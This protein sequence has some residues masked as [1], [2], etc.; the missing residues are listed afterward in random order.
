VELIAVL[1]T[2]GVL[3]LISLVLILVVVLLGVGMGLGGAKIIEG[4]VEGLARS[5]AQRE[6]EMRAL[7]LSPAGGSAYAGEIDGMAVQYRLRRI[8]S[9]KRRVTL[10]GWWVAVPTGALFLRPEVLIELGSDQRVGEATFDRQFVVRG[11]PAELA[12]L[13][14][15][16]RQALLAERGVK[17]EAGELGH[18]QSHFDPQAL[19]RLLP[20]ARTLHELPAEPSAR[21]RLATDDPA[22]A[23]RL[24]S[25]GALAELDPAQ[26]VER[27][28]SLQ[29][30]QDSSVRA[31]AELIL[32]EDQREPTATSSEAPLELRL[33]AGRALIRTGT[34]SQR[35]RVARSLLC[36][37]LVSLQGLGLE[38]AR[39]AGPEGEPALIEGV[40]VVDGERLG[41]L[42]LVLR[43]VGSV[44]AVPALRARQEQLSVLQGGL[45]SAIDHA[46]LALQEQ[47]GGERGGLALAGSPEQQGALSVAGTAGALSPPERA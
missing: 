30:D 9:G 5:R 39:S 1:G 15:S 40:A 19:R 4:V 36:Q 22:P 27:A 45:S 44:A 42:L 25:L 17:I 7:G 11:G 3:I 29:Q 23:V 8:K 16:V 20:L 32:D 21:L 2:L 10:H 18:E 38:L 13:T 34:S 6:A 24:R 46:V 28:T 43:E 41:Q 12:F 35:A 31:L 33:W 14:A 37:P 47:A 26:G